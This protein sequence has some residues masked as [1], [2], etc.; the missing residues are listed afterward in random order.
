MLSIYSHFSFFNFFLTK[1]SLKAFF[2]LISCEFY[3]F[4]IVFC[5][6]VCLFVCLFVCCFKVTCYQFTFLFISVL[7]IYFFFFYLTYLSLYWMFVPL[8]YIVEVQ[9]VLF[10]NFFH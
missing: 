6:F 8:F 3:C 10:F 9:A 1:V 7:F 2:S 4:V 5:V